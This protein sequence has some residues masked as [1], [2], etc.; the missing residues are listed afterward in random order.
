MYSDIQARGL[1][2]GWWGVIAPLANVVNLTRNAAAIARHRGHVP[3]P[4]YR[5]PEVRTPSL[6]PR[7]ATPV[8]SR[9]GPLAATAAV[10]AGL[11]F[12]VM[13]SLL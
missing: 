7:V 4:E 10:I 13:A 8:T 12:L 2:R 1:V 3:E 9:P 6:W 5:S 11:L